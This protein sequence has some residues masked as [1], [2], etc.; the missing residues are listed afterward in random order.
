[1]Y[2]MYV[3]S[4]STTNEIKV[5]MTNWT[6]QKKE[7][8]QKINSIALEVMRKKYYASKEKKRNENCMKTDILS[9]VCLFIYVFGVDKKKA[10]THKH[11]K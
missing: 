1:M 9:S 2:Y 4:S 6:A 11:M 5:P 3:V 10:H 8:N 7:R